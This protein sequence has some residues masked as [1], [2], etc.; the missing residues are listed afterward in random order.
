MISDKRQSR[1][2][3]SPTPEPASKRCVDIEGRIAEVNGV[4]VAARKAVESAGTAE[5]LGRARNELDFGEIR[6]RALI[7][8]RVAAEVGRLEENAEK[9]RAAYKRESDPIPPLAKR[10]KALEREIEDVRSE[11]SRLQY[12]AAEFSREKTAA[13]A[14]LRMFAVAREYPD[15]PDGQ[16]LRAHMAQLRSR[17]EGLGT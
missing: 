1:P 9:A 12:R 3:P 5:E 13:E 15:G 6:L 17:L 14:D 16:K 2:T 8:D 7:Q 11:L 4:I 10:E